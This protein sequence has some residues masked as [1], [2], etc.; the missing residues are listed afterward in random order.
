MVL[1]V[2]KDM[3]F[4]CRQIWQSSVWVFLCVSFKW[5][6]WINTRCMFFFFRFQLVCLSYI[7]SY[8]TVWQKTSGSLSFQLFRRVAAALPGMDTAQ[9][10]NRGDSILLCMSL[11]WF[12]FLCIVILLKAHKGYGGIKWLEQWNYAIVNLFFETL[13]FPS[14]FSNW[15][16]QNASKNW[17]GNPDTVCPWVFTF[18]RVFFFFWV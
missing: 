15:I 4:N 17:D 8:F 12:P 7:Q 13:V 10:N 18:V 16:L 6:F 1:Q 14:P 3:L 9:D 2:L 11:A 5:I